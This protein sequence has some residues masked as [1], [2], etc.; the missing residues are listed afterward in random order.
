MGWRRLAPLS[1]ACYK[2]ASRLEQVAHQAMI[3]ER[4]VAGI[5]MCREPS[6]TAVMT[7]GRADRSRTGSPATSTVNVAVSW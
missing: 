2:H 1:A 4:P 6:A 7:T 5:L 3:H